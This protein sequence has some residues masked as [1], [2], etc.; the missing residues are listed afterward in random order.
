MLKVVSP[1]T[2]TARV[3][4]ADPLPT[5][6]NAQLATLVK[7][8]PEGDEWLHELK[9]DGYRIGCRIDRGAV[10]LLSRNGKDWTERFPTACAAARRL[11]A[12]RAL[13]DGEVTVVLPDGRTSFQA[14]QNAYGGGPGEGDIVYFVFDLLHL[15]G[16]DVGRLPLEERKARLQR[17]VDRRDGVIRYA[18]HVVGHGPEVFAAA[19]RQRAEGIISK[20]RDLPYRPGRGPGWLKTK[21]I[22]RQEFIIGGFTDPE[23]SRV[24]LGALLIGVR[25]AAGQLVF[26]GKVGTGFTQK[27]ARELRQHLESIEQRDSP[28]AVRPAGWLGRNAHWVEPR[29]IAEVAFT[30]WTSDG[31]I[32]HPSF[33]GLRED[34][35]AADVIRERPRTPRLV[36][37][38]RRNEQRVKQRGRAGAKRVAPRRAVDGAAVVAGVPISHPDRVVYPDIPLTKLEL[39]RFYASIANWILPHLRG[40]PLTLVRCPEGVG[41]S[42]FYMKHAHLWA[43]AGLRRVAIPEKKKI[44]EY[45]VAD[46]LEAL[47]GLVQMG[48]LEIHTWN[49]TTDHLEQPDRIVL[50]L[51]PG[52]RVSW[53]AVIDAARVVRTALDA[54]G[55]E[56]FVKNTGGRGLHVVVPLEPHAQWS[57]CLEFARAVA[58]AVVR[59]DPRSYTTNFAKAGRERQILIDY[60][61]NNRTNT[62]IAAYSTRATPKAPVSTPLMWDELSPRMPA[63]HYTVRTIGKRLSGLRVDPWQAYWT[64]RQRIPSDAVKRLA[65]VR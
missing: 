41:T 33:Q 47:I 6:F 9:Y 57:E 56:S 54:L 63:D 37:R 53:P 7:A 15:D 13:I 10:Q 58:D 8:A 59:L 14:L 65:E 20:R 40:R 49:S 52:P 36:P 62:S 11:R 18:D 51:D 35:P 38:R 1:R 32:R 39:A 64:T 48:I 31:K 16:V 19:C 12:E 2:R 4:A 27:S 24:G 28:F 50:D 25:D 44:G 46:S 23:G 21:C 55:L 42:C 26:A 34:K 60:L 5:G 43:P 3:A 61:R 17:L 22:A 29:L 45:L 30:E